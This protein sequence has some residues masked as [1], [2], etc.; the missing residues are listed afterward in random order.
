MHILPVRYH[1]GQW[2]KLANG[3]STIS[4]FYYGTRRSTSSLGSLFPKQ[5]TRTR[6]YSSSNRSFHSAFGRLPIFVRGINDLDLTWRRMELIVGIMNSRTGRTTSRHRTE[7]VLRMLGWLGNRGAGVSASCLLFEVRGG[8]ES[9]L[10]K[11]N[12]RK[13]CCRLRG[14]GRSLLARGEGSCCLGIYAMEFG[15]YYTAPNDE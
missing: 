2:A 11:A 8:N 6:A 14:N 13:T 10:S 12:D 3:R 9:G 5:H 7:S 15:H 4:C 1:H